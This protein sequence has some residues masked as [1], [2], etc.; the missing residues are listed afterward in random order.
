[1]FERQQKSHCVR[2]VVGEGRVLGTLV[3]GVAGGQLK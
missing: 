3:K 1:M 2:S